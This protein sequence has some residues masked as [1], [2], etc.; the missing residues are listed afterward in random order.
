MRKSRTERCPKCG[1]LSVIK[2][3]RQKGHQ[4]Y[5]CKECGNMFTH[6][7]KDV[8]KGNRFVWLKWWILGKQTIKQI[9]DLSGYSERQLSRWFDEY[10]RSY[11][12]W[13]MQRREKV[14]LLIDGTWFPN[15]VCLVLYRDENIK[16]T[17]LYRIT[18]DEWEEE[19]VE[20]LIN[21]QN[22]GIEI[23][24]VTSD[25]GKNIIKAV[26]KACPN[27][28]RQRC[29]AHIQRECNTWLTQHP[30]SEAGR[31]L[32]RLVNMISKVKTRNDR[33]QWEIFLEQW[34]QTYKDW[35][36]KK[37]FKIQSHTE[38]YTHKMVRKSY[39]HLK[40]ALPN[41]FLFID[42]PDVPRTTNAL[43]S[44]FGHMYENISLHRGLSK[45]HCQNHVKWY[46][47]FRNQS[48]KQK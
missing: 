18:D 41:M 25:G 3:G 46:L 34:Y 12:E 5:K 40:H 28:I 17:L 32:K 13:Q 39:I 48:N 43:E 37:S 36:T 26:A 38:W 4:R 2:W 8:S 45:T 23:R 44:F 24:S 6:R 42:N 7:R 22:L 31:E 19:I 10:L 27:A 16:T 9:S 11:P 47:Y 21:I 14:N 20:D 33:L 29:L 35:I 1:S 30:Q 15:R